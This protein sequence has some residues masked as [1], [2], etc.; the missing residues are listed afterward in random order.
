MVKRCCYPIFP[1][2]WSTIHFRHY[3]PLGLCS[4]GECAISC[5]SQLSIL[6][7]P[8]IWVPWLTTCESLPSRR[9]PVS[10]AGFQQFSGKS[11]TQLSASLKWREINWERGCIL[12]HWAHTACADGNMLW[13]FDAR[14]LQATQSEDFWTPSLWTVSPRTLQRHRTSVG[15]S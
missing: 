3:C 10:V 1:I 7:P 6:D 11:E 4:Y 9:Q 5:I 13:V 2:V 14:F 15:S 8:D 12:Q